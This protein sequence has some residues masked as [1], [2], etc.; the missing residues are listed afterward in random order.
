MVVEGDGDLQRLASESTKEWVPLCV[1]A[2]TTR[3]TP[4]TQQ[5]I[6]GAIDACANRVVGQKASPGGTMHSIL[7]IT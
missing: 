5:L 6:D 3:H 1:V 4:S 2:S 7:Q